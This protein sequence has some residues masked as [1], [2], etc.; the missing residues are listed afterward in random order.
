L[1]CARMILE[2]EGVKEPLIDLGIKGGVMTG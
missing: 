2:G 1:Q